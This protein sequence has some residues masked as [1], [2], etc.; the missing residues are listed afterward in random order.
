MTKVST[1]PKRCAI[2][3]VAT[4]HSWSGCSSGVPGRASPIFE[5]YSVIHVEI[6]SSSTVATPIAYLYVG[7]VVT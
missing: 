1:P 6:A 7:W 4:F 2:S 5:W 3:F